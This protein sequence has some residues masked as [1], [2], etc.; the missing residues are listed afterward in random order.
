[1]GPRARKIVSLRRHSIFLLIRCVSFSY[2]R[3]PAEANDT[4]SGKS[5]YCKTTEEVECV[6]TTEINLLREE[7]VTAETCN[8][9][10]V[11]DGFEYKPVIHLLQ[12]PSRVVHRSALISELNGEPLISSRTDR[13]GKEET[14]GY[15]LHI[16]V[17]Y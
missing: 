3:P 9:S 10:D 14:F 5:R 8:C 15:E 17:Y 6:E 2:P 16:E 4:F 12:Y 1:M 11:C 7:N 13:S